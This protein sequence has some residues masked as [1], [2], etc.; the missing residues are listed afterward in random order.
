M[1]TVPKWKR[2]GRGLYCENM[3]ELVEELNKMGYCDLEIAQKVGAA[4]STVRNWVK[5]KD[6][7]KKFARKLYQLIRDNRSVEAIDQSVQKEEKIT[8]IRNFESDN[9]G[10]PVRDKIKGFEGIMPEYFA[11]V[12]AFTPNYSAYCSQV[13]ELLR[14]ARKCKLSDKQIADVAG[15]QEESLKGWEK[16]E[17]GD[18]NKAVKLEEFLIDIGAIQPV[19]KL[20]QN[21]IEE[22]RRFFGF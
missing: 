19:D 21:C 16:E 18:L 10:K 9:L 11:I 17:Y 15:M 12:P 14:I 13:K 5:N 1:G 6:G 8:E 20:I 22:I 3:N 4:Q 2:G 7:D